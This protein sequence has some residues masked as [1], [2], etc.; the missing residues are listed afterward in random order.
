MKIIV[1]KNNEIKK[2]GL[3]SR[4]SIKLSLEISVLLSD[5]E[6]ILIQNYHDP[7]ISADVIWSKT[8]AIAGRVTSNKSGTKLSNYSVI[9]YTDDA[10]GNI[11]AMDEL[12]TATISQLRGALDHIKYIDQSINQWEGEKI[13]DTNKVKNGDK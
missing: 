9:Y 4:K 3:M 5:E 2:A 1:K 12:E 13:Y 10:S 7:D 8:S 11:T 6:K